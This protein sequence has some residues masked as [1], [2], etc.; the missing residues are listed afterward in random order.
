MSH[1]VRLQKDV[2]LPREIYRGVALPFAVIVAA[3]IGKDLLPDVDVHLGDNG[4]ESRHHRCPIPIV[5]RNPKNFFESFYRG[6]LLSRLAAGS[7]LADTN[8]MQ[9]KDEKKSCAEGTGDL[10]ECNPIHKPSLLGVFVLKE[11]I[12]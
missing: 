6:S 5:R 12:S 11:R 9:Q 10:D 8:Y 2:K 7:I 4:L 3:R 1:L